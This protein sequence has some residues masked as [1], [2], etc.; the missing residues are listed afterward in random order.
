MPSS[1]DTATPQLQIHTPADALPIQQRRSDAH[2]HFDAQLAHHVTSNCWH[3]QRSH[4]LVRYTHVTSNCWHRQRSH[5]LVRYTQSTSMQS[6]VLANR[7][8]KT[9]TKQCSPVVL[10]APSHTLLLLPCRCQC[11]WTRCRTCCPVSS[12]RAAA[13]QSLALPWRPAGG[14]WRWRLR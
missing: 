4:E 9:Y 13:W 10:S 11:T 8:Y 12:S 1:N 7:L 5:E 6:V 3:R 14:R 2:K